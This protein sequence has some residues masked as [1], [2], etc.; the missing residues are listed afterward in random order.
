MWHST[1]NQLHHVVNRRLRRS[2]QG[3]NG[4]R[5]AQNM[6]IGF[7][8]TKKLKIINAT[9]ILQGVTSLRNIIIGGPQRGS[10]GPQSPAALS[11]S[12][13]YYVLKYVWIFEKLLS[14][15][16]GLRICLLNTYIFVYS[17]NN[18]HAAIAYNHLSP[19]MLNFKEAY[20]SLQQRQNA[21]NMSPL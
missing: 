6:A 8:D 1:I 9:K 13:S 17:S 15:V 20:A 12:A 4:V 21:S 14:P 16:S 7:V 3:P 10:L 18:R 5:W 11:T 2:S 19:T